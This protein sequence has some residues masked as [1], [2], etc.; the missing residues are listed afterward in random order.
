[1]HGA[2]VQ[3][4]LSEDGNEEANPGTTL[5]GCSVRSNIGA[6][7]G[8]AVLAVVPVTRPTGSAL[9]V[10]GPAERQPQ[11]DFLLQALV[12]E[13]K[14]YEEEAFARST[15][16]AYGT[17]ARS[18]VAFCVAFACLG[19]LEPLLPASDD[20]LVWFI[21]F[22][23]WYWD[24]PSK[25]VMPLT[26]RNPMDMSPP[27]DV[28]VALGVGIVGGERRWCGRMCYVLFTEDGETDCS[29]GGYAGHLLRRGGATA[30]KRLE[31]HI[32][33]IKHQGDWR[34]NWYERY[35]ELEPE[36]RLI[37]PGV[38]AAAAAALNQ[39]AQRS[40]EPRRLGHWFGQLVKKGCRHAHHITEPVR[41]PV[42][43]L[44]CGAQV[45]SQ[46]VEAKAMPSAVES[47]EA[48]GPSTPELHGEVELGMGIFLQAVATLAL[49]EAE[50]GMGTFLQAVATLALRGG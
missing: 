42:E 44:R 45:A 15:K 36:Q 23:S 39:A 32:V 6:P 4:V 37:F 8:G 1:M 38:M 16:G 5:E 19:C 31:M 41:H 43:F 7:S 24:L 2:P 10:M 20:M 22:L 3:D 9:F 12:Q 18:S 46:V 14:R 26:L 49:G 47:D 50:H 33:Y 30:A 21:T 34:S 17:G 25:L 27:C 35:C 48:S 28:R 29:Q 13:Q 40:E 11:T